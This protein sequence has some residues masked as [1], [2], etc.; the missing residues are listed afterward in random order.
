MAIEI[1][2]PQL[3]LTMTEGTVGK[4]KKNVGDA[5]EVGDALVE[6]MTDK[7][8][9]EVE[10]TAAGVLRAICAKE[11]EE[12]PVQALLCIIGSADEPIEV[13]GAAA[14]AGTAESSAAPAAAPAAGRE[15]KASP[16]AKRLAEEKGIDIAL[17]AGSG[18]DGRIVVSDVEK[19]LES[20][21][22]PQ[23][24]GGRVKASPYAKKVAEELGVDIAAVAGTGPDGRIVEEDVRR[25]AANK[26]QGSQT[27]APAPAAAPAA[28]TAAPAQGQPLSGMRKVIAER[29]TA[30]K[31]TAP[32][33]TLMTE[34]NV[35]ATVAFR[36]EINAR[37]PETR[38]S[39]TDIL[40]KMVA[41]ALRRFPNINSSLIDGAIV[42]HDEINI[43]IAVALDN[44]LLVPVLR[45]AD[46][47]GLKEIRAQNKDII[48][49]ARTNKL[50]L[51]MLSGGTFTISNLGSYDV[52]G[53]TPI[54]NQPESAILG[55]GR[56]VRKPAVVNDEIAAASLMT[57]SLSFDHRVVDGAQAAEFLKCIK[58][59]LEDPI[60]MFL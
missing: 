56:I 22:A 34:V 45:N 32:H 7:I 29:M 35:D 49:K 40:T 24:A 42:A 3:G 60:N 52:D 43:G 26:A 59:Y 17:V 4:W 21:P 48:E 38:F 36:S 16:A 10:S 6:I 23:P 18:P 50:G 54:I 39:Y 20:A 25:A 15:V 41:T 37:N 44:G 27:A 12:L 19:Y 5:V 9:S 2:M 8:T 33:V 31:H 47:L 57:L 53:F 13:P 55:V 14:G 1:K 46:K 11:G 51:D 30:S 58:T 28:K